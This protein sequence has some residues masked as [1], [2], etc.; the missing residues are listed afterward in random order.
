[1][2]QQNNNSSPVK[3]KNLILAYILWW[4]LGWLG[5]HRFYLG[6]PFTGIAF[7]GLIILG[8][9]VGIIAWLSLIVW[10]FLD[11]FLVCQYVQKANSSIDGSNL[12]PSQ[13][14]VGWIVILMLWLTGIK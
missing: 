4:F 1:M 13:A 5:L 7:I 2:D 10:W 11:A 12:C 3:G 14:D 9:F 6:K 8:L